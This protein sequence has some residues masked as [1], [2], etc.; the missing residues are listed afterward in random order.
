MED[1]RSFYHSHYV[2]ARRALVLPDEAISNYWEAASAS[3]RAPRSD[4]IHLE[5]LQIKKLEGRK[6][7]SNLPTCKPENL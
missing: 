5:C 4:M 6:T 2:I 3:T 1:M 7:L